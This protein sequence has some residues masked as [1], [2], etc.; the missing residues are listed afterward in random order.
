M[1]HQRP[2]ADTSDLVASRIRQD[3]GDDPGWTPLH[4]AIINGKALTLEDVEAYGLDTVETPDVA[5]VRPIHLACLGG[6]YQAVKTLLD[7]RADI[8][9]PCGQYTTTPLLTAARHNHLDIV[10]LL[11]ASGAVENV[12]HKDSLGN[13]ALRYAALNKTHSPDA[14]RIHALL[15]DHGAM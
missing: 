10:E 4:H 13:T 6:N 8:N 11:L 14:E 12:N 15:L 1:T 3:L 5:G 9:T 2:D 7:L